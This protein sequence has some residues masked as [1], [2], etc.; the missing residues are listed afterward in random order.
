MRLR[1]PPAGRAQPPS[2]QRAWYSGPDDQWTAG[3]PR[4]LRGYAVTAAANAALRAT[5]QV[6][7]E[8]PHVQWRLGDITE[9]LGVPI[10]ADGHVIAFL[11]LD[12]FG[13]GVVFDASAQ[14]T[15]MN[16]AVQA[17]LLLASRA[18]REREAQRTRELEALVQITAS[19]M[20]AAPTTSSTPSVP[21]R[22][23][24]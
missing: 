13:P 20:P 22:M 9:T 5:F 17:A 12:R 21:C 24:S 2:G 15:G 6:G 23:W 8:Q 1:R 16:F 18:R 3:T 7:G 11:N 10:T 4:V 19:G 14:E